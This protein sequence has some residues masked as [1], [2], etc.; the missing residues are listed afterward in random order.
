M[1]GVRLLVLSAWSAEVM[2]RLAKSRLMPQEDADNES[3]NLGFIR[4]W[5][6][7]SRFCPEVGSGPT[8]LKLMFPG[9]LRDLA[10]IN[11]H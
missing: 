11:S 6:R 4:G 2:T 10:T 3:Y 5:L 7:W 1:A 9:N 8:S